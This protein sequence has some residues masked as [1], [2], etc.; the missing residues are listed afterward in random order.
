MGAGYSGL[1]QITTVLPSYLKL[2]RALVSGID[3]DPDRAALVAAL[4]GYSSQVGSLL[5][6]EGVETTS[7]LRILQQI[8]VPLVQ[9]FRLSRP[10]EP[11]PEVDAEDASSRHLEASLTAATEPAGVIDPSDWY[12]VGPELERSSSAPSRVS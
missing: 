2:D 8:G 3:S 5:I 9:G 4:S 6:A 10:G 7:E 11:W 12:A 1:R